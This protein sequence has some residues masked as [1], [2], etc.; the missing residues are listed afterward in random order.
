MVLT[1]L[2]QYP[3]IHTLPHLGYTLD[4]YATHPWLY[5][6]HWCVSL[7]LTP[8]NLCV[9]RIWHRWSTIIRPPTG[10]QLTFKRYSRRRPL[11]ILTIPY[12]SVRPNLIHQVDML[13]KR[14]KAYQNLPADLTLPNG[15]WLGNVDRYHGLPKFTRPYR[16]RSIRL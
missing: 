4:Q 3:T 16:L 11:P 12:H 10:G 6:C 9:R 15:P 2:I 1:A 13:R 8:K 5:A 14:E 7:G